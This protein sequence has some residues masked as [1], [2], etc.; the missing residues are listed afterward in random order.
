MQADQTLDTKGLSCP[1]PV[2][3]SKKSIDGMES[4]Q[5]LEIEATDKGAKNDLSAWAKSNGHELLQE[6]E[7]EGVL[8]FWVKKG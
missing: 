3:K 7:E 5:I 8:K 2:V 1:M 4:G 6:T